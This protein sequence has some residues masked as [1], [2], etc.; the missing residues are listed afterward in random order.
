MP[1]ACGGQDPAYPGLSC[2][3]EQGHSM[4]AIFECEFM[5]EEVG[6]AWREKAMKLERM[7][8]AW[9]EHEGL[10]LDDDGTAT[11]LMNKVE[12][13]D[14]SRIARYRERAWAA[15]AKVSRWEDYFVI[16]SPHWM[17]VLSYAAHALAASSDNGD[18]YVSMQIRAAMTA[19]QPIDDRLA[20]AWREGLRVGEAWE[21]R[22]WQWSAGD[23]SRKVHGLTQS[24]ALDRPQNP[25]DEKAGS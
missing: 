19:Y 22:K 3:L 17:N 2:Y 1:D 11:I 6:L 23:I 18:A 10:M 20:E 21:R 14:A 15:E 25:Y 12:E 8:E 7:V 24:P 4:S 16:D 13:R 9:R 5:T